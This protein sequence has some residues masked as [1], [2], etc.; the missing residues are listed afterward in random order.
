MTDQKSNQ[1][2]AG[3]QRS[4]WLSVAY[5][6]A[7]L[8]G[9]FAGVEGWVRRPFDSA[10]SSPLARVGLALRER[11]V[12]A[13]PEDWKLLKADADAVRA[14]LEPELREAFDLVSALRGL[15]SG[16]SPDFATAE[17]LCK[18]LR[19]GR[20]DRASLEELKERSRP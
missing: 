15:A 4:R 7:V 11:N 18:K 2:A 20:C 19:W 1:G 17:S 9:Y 8:L 6:V 13:T 10:S 14:T 12:A 16:G 3:A 5:A